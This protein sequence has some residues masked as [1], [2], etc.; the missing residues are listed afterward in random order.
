MEVYDQHGLVGVMVRIAD[1]VMADEVGRT[2]ESGMVGVL[3][4]TEEAVMAVAMVHNA[5]SLADL[6]VGTEEVVAAG[7][8]VD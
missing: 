8:G 2:D 6:V 3:G 4:R 7:T 1:A 5:Q